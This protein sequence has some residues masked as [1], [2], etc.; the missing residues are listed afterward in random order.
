[1]VVFTSCNDMGNNDSKFHVIEYSRCLSKDAWLPASTG[2]RAEI[3]GEIQTF[4][5]GGCVDVFKT[6][7]PELS[8][9]SSKGPFPRRGS[10]THYGQWFLSVPWGK[11]EPSN[12]NVQIYNIGIQNAC[13]LHTLLRRGL[14]KGWPDATIA[15]NNKLYPQASFLLSGQN[16]SRDISTMY[17]SCFP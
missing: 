6:L 14:W 11:L 7:N 2:N 5:S 10:L 16:E 13:L 3:T 12:T 4:V 8:Y 17:Q 15:L 9:V 1:M